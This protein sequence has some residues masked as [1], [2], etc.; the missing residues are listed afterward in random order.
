MIFGSNSGRE[1]ERFFGKS[2]EISGPGGAGWRMIPAESVGY[3]AAQM[4]SDQGFMGVF[5]GS[6]VLRISFF[7]FRIHGG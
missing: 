4:I 5:A 3:R 2:H 7:A 6:S 1:Q